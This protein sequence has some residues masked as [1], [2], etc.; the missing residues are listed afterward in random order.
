M[1]RLRE[2][3]SVLL[4]F[5]AAVLIV[6]VLAAITVDSSIAFLAQ[7]ELANATAA[8]ANDAAGEAVDREAFYGQDRVELDPAAVE[9]VAVE[10]VR[11]AID[12]SRHRGLEIRAVANPP[13]RAGCPWT[14]Q[15]WASSRVSYVFAKAVPGG[16][17]EASVRA[18]SVAAPEEGATSGPCGV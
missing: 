6:L 16:P 12:E 13:L 11:L 5:P 18:T 17:D 1:I 14:V 3:G 7:R 9:A 15:V 2:R 10:R 8:A 4:L